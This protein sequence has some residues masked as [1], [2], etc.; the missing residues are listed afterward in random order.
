M[1][2]RQLYNLAVLEHT[3]EQPICYSVAALGLNLQHKHP[4]TW[5]SQHTYL[6]RHQV[7]LEGELWPSRRPRRQHAILALPPGQPLADHAP[8]GAERVWEGRG[9]E[10]QLVQLVQLVQHGRAA[11]GRSVC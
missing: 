4:R 10:V 9:V 2:I 1:A 5:P 7:S 8:N 3:S 6:K 11:K